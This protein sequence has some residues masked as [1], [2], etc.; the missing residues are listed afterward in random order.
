MNL[1]TSKKNFNINH[2]RKFSVHT[3]YYERKCGGYIL[4]GV[5]LRVF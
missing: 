4:R 5:L 2:P 3:L 1:R